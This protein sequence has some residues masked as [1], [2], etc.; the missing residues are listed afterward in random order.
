M[1]NST[2]SN[3]QATRRN[4]YK[5][6]RILGLTALVPI[7]CW[8]ISGLSHP[9]MS[10]WFR[11]F[12][13]E[14]TF[15]PIPQSQMQPKLSLQ[16]ILDQHHISSLRNFS[17]VNFN[18]H[19]YYQV[20]GQDST[21]TYYAADNGQ[22]LPSADRLYAI[23]LARYFTQDS[24]S[25][26]KSITLQKSFDSYYQPIN[27]LLPVW[28]VSFN[29]PDGMDIYVETGQ[30]RMGTFNNQLRKALLMVFEQ[31][32]TWD[33]LAA[34]AG[35]TVRNAV[36]LCIVSILF[37]SMLSGLII[38]G[39]FWKRFKEITQKN[40]T[41]GTADKRFMHRYHRQ[42]GLCVSFLMLLFFVSAGFHLAVKLHNDQPE[43]APFSQLISR[44]EI[45]TDNLHLPIADSL[46]RKQGLAKFNGKVYYQLMTVKKEMVYVDAAT[47]ETLAN[48]DARYAQSLADYYR[49]QSSEKPNISQV[50][51][52]TE[53][54]GFINKRLPVEMVSYPGNDNWYIETSTA[55]LAAHI[56]GIDRIEGFSF[57]FLHK[58]F[59]MTWAGK[60]IRDLVSMLSALSVL[61]VALLG[62]IS[63]L[64][65]KQA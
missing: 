4:F 31:L 1:S 53:E 25:A 2:N 7:I 57:I 55:K 11:P 16:Q 33:F 52:F 21:Y 48:G 36:L 14:E 65:N 61:A 12:I 50:K 46:T 43:K 60:D 22:L 42:M 56:A 34:I 20:L 38:Y 44:D 45:K 6:H 5:W 9:F 30:S 47:G 28:K 26:I 62:F 59:W 58:F 35:D 32:H 39:L 8:T 23:Y 17:L 24:T 10:N 63:F 29:R 64:K 41:K 54:Y 40:K 27:H 51:Q 13:P 18:H 49:G 3:K 19:T 15:Q 37:L